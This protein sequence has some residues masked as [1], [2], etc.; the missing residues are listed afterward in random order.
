[1]ELSEG[2]IRLPIVKPPDSATRGLY[3]LLFKFGK[4][5][6]EN[7]VHNKDLLE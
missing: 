7:V 3:L 4:K 6:S 2:N 5:L 1:M